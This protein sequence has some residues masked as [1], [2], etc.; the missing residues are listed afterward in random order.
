MKGL[1]GVSWWPRGADHVISTLPIWLW[2][3]L[4]SLSLPPLI[5]CQLSTVIC[6]GQRHK[7]RDLYLLGLYRG[8]TLGAALSCNQ[9][10]SVV[11]GW[12]N[13]PLG[14]PASHVV[15]NS[16]NQ[17]GL[18]FIYNS[19]QNALETGG[20]AEGGC[21][22]LYPTRNFELVHHYF[23][24]MFKKSWP[25]SGYAATAFPQV[26]LFYFQSKSAVSIKLKLFQR[27]Q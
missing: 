2:L 4:H 19:Y 5:S 1:H 17:W 7:K 13:K 26:I 21:D 12:P 16:A 20:T 3:S 6:P 8:E 25:S 27:W 23:L 11:H 15:T 22:Q 9:C 10:I 18:A 14:R 24:E